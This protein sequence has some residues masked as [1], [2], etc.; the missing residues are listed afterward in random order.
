MNFLRS[1]STLLFT[2]ASA[3]W[4][5]TGR[6]AN[7]NNNNNNNNNSNNN[8]NNNNLESGRT[9]AENT[10]SKTAYRL[11]QISKVKIKKRSFLFEY[12][13]K[14]GIGSKKKGTAKAKIKIHLLV[15][16][17]QSMTGGI[18]VIA[19]LIGRSHSPAA[20]A[21]PSST[22]TKNNNNNNI[23]NNNNN[24]NN[25]IKSNYRWKFS[26]PVPNWLLPSKTQ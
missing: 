2:A 13:I 17:R 4:L 24:K 1:R 9:H 25:T 6:G 22:K 26:L 10:T 15:L 14:K 21:N 8:N 7:N 12:W 20:I 3:V 11:R 18:R 23:N 19:L 16:F 5:R